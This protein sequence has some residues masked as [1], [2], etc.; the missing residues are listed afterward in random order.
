MGMCMWCVPGLASVSVS[1]DHSFILFRV[2]ARTVGVSLIVPHE[3]GIIRNIY[4]DHRRN[5]QGC[6]VTYKGVLPERDAA[7]EVGPLGNHQ[8]CWWPSGKTP[9]WLT[10]KLE[11]SPGRHYWV[12]SPKQPAANDS[13][14]RTSH[15]GFE[16]VYVKT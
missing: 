15:M 5:P 9:T 4:T 8:R 3:L 10:T 12:R 11:S 13:R 16:L 7:R 14:E 6:V 2:D 1:I